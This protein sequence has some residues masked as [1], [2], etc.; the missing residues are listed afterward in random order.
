MDKRNSYWRLK[1]MIEAVDTKVLTI[2][3]LK[4][5]IIKCIGSHQKT[6]ENSIRI[7]GDTGLIKDVGNCRFE[8]LK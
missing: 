3:E 6:V 4:S 2:H 7:L 5:L 1:E 8:V